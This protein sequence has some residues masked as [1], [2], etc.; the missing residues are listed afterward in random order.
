MLRILNDVLN[1]SIP[2]KNRSY[3]VQYRAF[4]G[5][6]I[7]LDAVDEAPSLLFHPIGCIGMRY[8]L[9]SGVRDL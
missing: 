1:L 7:H 9:L 8:L 4:S 3:V 2:R 5:G 6:E